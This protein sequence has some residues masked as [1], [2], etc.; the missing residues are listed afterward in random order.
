MRSTT[1]RIFVAL[2]LLLAYLD[3]SRISF[4]TVRHYDLAFLTH[5]QAWD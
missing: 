5:K 2:L 4:Q 3:G 1:I